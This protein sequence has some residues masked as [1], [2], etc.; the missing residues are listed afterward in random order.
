MFKSYLQARRETITENNPQNGICF[1]GAVDPPR[2][3]ANEIRLAF[4]LKETNGNKNNGEHN[5]ILEDWDYM[6]WVNRQA[7][8]I[9]PLYRSV[10]RNV[11]M[12]AKMFAVRTR[13]QRE[14]DASEFIDENGIVVNEALLD[15]LKD[16][17]IINLKKSWGVEQTDWYQ[18]K[19]Y[20]ENPERRDILI[21]QIEAL[22]PTVVLCGGTFDFAYEIFGEGC[23]I[24]EIVSQSGQKVCFFKVNEILF[25][26]CYHPS[27][28]GWSRYKSFDHIKNIFDV[29]L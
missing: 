3:F 28:P 6:K 20:L 8:N 11:A 22:K 21:Y 16:I 5:E 13:G 25:V 7:D 1:D 24:S 14:L 23:S 19:Q 4:L 29:V 18:M 9:E 26:Q 15:S 17:A 2:Y 10:Y 12:W 27:R